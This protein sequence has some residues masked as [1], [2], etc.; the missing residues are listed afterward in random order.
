MKF[1]N[2]SF[3]LPHLIIVGRAVKAWIPDNSI[4]QMIQQNTS[5]ICI[6]LIVESTFIKH[7][8]ISNQRHNKRETLFK[9]TIQKKSK[10]L[11]QADIFDNTTGK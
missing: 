10:A 2:I 6:L 9:N 7:A 4:N 8:G 5:T 3:N 11:L 1:L